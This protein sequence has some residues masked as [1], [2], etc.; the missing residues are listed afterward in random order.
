MT[1]YLN[2]V[3]SDLERHSFGWARIPRDDMVAIISEYR[4]LAESLA[5][6]YGCVYQEWAGDGHMFLFESADAAVQFGLRLIESWKQARESVGSRSGHPPMALRL[7]CHYGDCTPLEGKTGWIGRGNSV[8]K[9]V[10]AE[11]G[12]DCL[13]ATET[14]LDLIDLPLYEVSEAGTYTL[15]GD[16]LPRR[17]LYR[18]VSF[19]RA[20]FE[21]K[22]AAQLTAQEWF[23]KGV[24]LIGTAREDSFDESDCYRDALKLRPDF[25][26]AHNNLAVVLKAQGKQPEAAQHYQEA[27]RLCPEYPEAHYNYATLLTATR[28]LAGAAGHYQAALARRAD[29]VDAHHGYANVLKQLGDLPGA[30]HHYREALRLRPDYAEAHNNY[31]ILL[32]ETADP[33]KAVEHYREAIRLRPDYAEAHYNYALLLEDTGQAGEAEGHYREALRLRPEYPEARNNLATLLH[34]AGNLREAEEHYR[35]ALRLRPDDPEVH[36]NFALLL[37]A[38]GDESEAERHFSIAHELAPARDAV[39]SA[40]EPPM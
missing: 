22:P 31:A 4:Y 39:R 17:T 33:A 30:A 10:E 36:Y 16:T 7:G 3:F 19:D 26:A 20:A 13:F 27:L 32:E 6:Q 18:L 5:S 9:R 34:L 15:K 25:A 12:G 35:E 23:L 24:A 21:A 38:K 29:Y 37:R 11:A 40:I 8:A 28:R 14:V 1:R 2:V